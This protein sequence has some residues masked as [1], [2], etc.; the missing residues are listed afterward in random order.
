LPTKFFDSR[1]CS[2]VGLF[3]LVLLD[4]LFDP[5]DPGPDTM[6]RIFALFPGFD[7]IIAGL[8]GAVTNDVGG[9]PGYF[10]L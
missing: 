1:V 9:R 3:I 5:L 4:G 2:F 8:T 10:L 6:P 7:V